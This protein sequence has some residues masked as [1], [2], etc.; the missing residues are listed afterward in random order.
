MDE[1]H[2]PELVVTEAHD[3]YSHRYAGIPCISDSASYRYGWLLADMELCE[4]WMDP[5]DQY[6]YVI[7]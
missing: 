4:E 2:S 5:N 3:G 7:Q 6:A 1:R